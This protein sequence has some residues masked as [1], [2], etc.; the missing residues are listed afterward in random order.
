MAAV[1]VPEFTTAEKQQLREA[2]ELVGHMPVMDKLFAGGGLGMRIANEDGGL[3]HIRCARCP[4]VWLVIEQ[5]GLDYDDAV[6]KL[7]VEL[8]D[9][10]PLKGR[11]RPNRT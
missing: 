7:D 1:E 2:C 11:L 10:A 4:T 5:P 9:T 3:P 8:K 6:T